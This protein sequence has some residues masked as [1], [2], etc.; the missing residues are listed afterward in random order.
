MK[1][2]KETNIEDIITDKNRF[3]NEKE[4]SAMLGI[5]YQRLK[6]SIRASGSLPFYRMNSRIS[7]RISDLEEY[8]QKCRVPAKN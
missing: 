1:H 4:A 2:I 3:I 6:R 7:Y 8:I 5:T